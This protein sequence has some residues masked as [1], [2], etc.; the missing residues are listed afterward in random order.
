MVDDS[1]LVKKTNDSLILKQASGQ[2]D[3]PQTPVSPPSFDKSPEEE[4]SSP[5]LKTNNEELQ[6]LMAVNKK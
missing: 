1:I 4:N 6:T 2:S 5:L 3:N